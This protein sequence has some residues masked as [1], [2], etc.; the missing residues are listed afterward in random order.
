[1]Q[2]AVGSEPNIALVLVQA[3]LGWIRRVGSRFFKVGFRG[4]DRLSSR[5]VNPAGLTEVSLP[6]RDCGAIFFVV[7]VVAGHEAVLRS[8]S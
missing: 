8:S 6:L 5:V 7:Q 4:Q 3:L 2:C 1:L